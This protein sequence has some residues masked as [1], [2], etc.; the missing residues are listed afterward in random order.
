MCSTDKCHMYGRNWSCP[1]ACGTLEE[2]AADISGYKKGIIVQTKGE[3]EDEFDGEGMMET[4]A[5]HK[6]HFI[7]M[8]DRLKKEFPKLL[9]LGAGCCTRCAKCSYPGCTL[10][11]SGETFFVD[12]SIW[13]AGNTGLS[14]QRDR[15]LLRT[16]ND[17]LYQL[18][19]P[20]IKVFMRRKSQPASS[21]VICRKNFRFYFCERLT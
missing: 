6:E 13:N 14:G 3:L 20:G 5:L 2:C 1:P 11:I 21:S 19:F 8:H 9:S 15:I 4:E 18:F 7:K 17:H 10:P 12:G 16:W